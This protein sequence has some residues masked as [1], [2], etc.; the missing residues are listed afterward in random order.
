MAA[1]PQASEGAVL[2]AA[3]LQDT[4]AHEMLL[5]DALDAE[6]GRERKHTLTTSQQYFRVSYIGLCFL[7]LFVAYGT[8]QNFL[9]TLFP[10]AGYVSMFL[11]YAGFA[12]GSVL[13]GPLMPYLSIVRWIVVSALAYAFFV[14][15]INF[16]ILPLFLFASF[17]LGLF[18]GPLWLNEGMY[19]VYVAQAGPAPM[20]TLTSIFL[21]L[22]SSSLAVGCIIVILI[23]TLGMP[24]ASVMIILSILGAVAC[25]LMLFI[26]TP[27]RPAAAPDSSPGFIATVRSMATTV[28]EIPA[29]VHV[30]AVQQGFNQAVSLAIMPTLISSDLEKISAVFLA[31]SISGT[32]ASMGW[33]LLFDARGYRALLLAHAAIGVAVFA[34]IIAFAQID[35]L[36]WWFIIPGVICGAFD[37]GNQ[38]MATIV[39]TEHLDRIAEVTLCVYRVIYSVAV[40]S[41]SLLAL[42]LPYYVISSTCIVLLGVAVTLFLRYLTAHPDIGQHAH[43]LTKKQ[44]VTTSDNEH[45]EAGGDHL[46]EETGDRMAG[47]ADKPGPHVDVE[48]TL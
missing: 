29:F 34:I 19:V 25:V 1:A 23:L 38:N 22:F 30:Y 35:V 11:I 16:D 12:I 44:P 8:A 14:A 21:S 31:Y 10:T 45:D 28:R 17:Q 3:E 42:Y 41:S 39:I 43:R 26:P 4:G 20:G 2:E 27:P 37:Q 32:L 6:Q 7:L 15:T 24:E 46:D 13:A 40:A 33:G 47:A 18:A 48:S 9:T 5:P 36:W